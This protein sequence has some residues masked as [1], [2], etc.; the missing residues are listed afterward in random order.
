[1]SER[2]ASPR[3]G[4]APWGAAITAAC[5]RAGLSA[6]AAARQ[7]AISEARWRQVAGGYQV[8]RGA[9]QD[10]DGADEPRYGT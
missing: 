1:M 10:A 6:R 8:V 3:P 7:A 2:S 9:A 5:A 4:P